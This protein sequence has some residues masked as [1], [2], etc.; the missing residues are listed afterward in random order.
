[1]ISLRPDTTYVITMNSLISIVSGLSR[2]VHSSHGSSD[3]C[4]MDNQKKM[5][6]GNKIVHIYRKSF[7][8]GKYPSRCKWVCGT[9]AWKNTLVIS[10]QSLPCKGG[11]HRSLLRIR[12][13]FI[14]FG[15]YQ[16][17]Y[18]GSKCGAIP[19]NFFLV[20]EIRTGWIEFIRHLRP[21][22]LCRSQACQNYLNLNLNGRIVIYL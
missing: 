1:M 6:Y 17:K 4:W 14:Y 8:R 21:R 15:W 3:N 16:H 5:F 7:E 10:I 20:V 12:E 13:K 2:Y 22:A 18:L 11:W 19:I 9:N